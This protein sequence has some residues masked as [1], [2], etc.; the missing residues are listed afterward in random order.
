M[1]KDRKTFFVVLTSIVLVF[2]GFIAIYFGSI[3]MKQTT[4]NNNT[5][6]RTR[7]EQ[8]NRNFEKFNLKCQTINIQPLL[9]QN[10][11]FSQGCK[12]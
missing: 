1:N 8:S 9:A 7:N 4:V 5:F 10:F 6:K 11:K 12:S 3:N 2:I